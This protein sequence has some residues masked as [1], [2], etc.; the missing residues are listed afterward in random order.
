[1]KG[2]GLAFVAS[3]SDYISSIGKFK[4]HLACLQIHLGTWSA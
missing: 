3:L 1:M 4:G 2:F